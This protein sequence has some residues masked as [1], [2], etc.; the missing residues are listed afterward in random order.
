MKTGKLQNHGNVDAAF[1]E[2]GFAIGNTLV[3]IK[4]S[5]AAMNVAA[6]TKRLLKW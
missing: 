6:A 5:L 3:V 2:C 4:V 1:I